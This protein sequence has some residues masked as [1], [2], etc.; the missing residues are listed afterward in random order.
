MGGDPSFLEGDEVSSIDD[1]A[2]A[3][4]AAGGD[5]AFLDSN[6]SMDKDNSKIDED[7]ESKQ[8]FIWDGVVDEDAHLLDD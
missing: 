6:H 8:K 3:L 1:D 7:K 4:E 2:A 5:P